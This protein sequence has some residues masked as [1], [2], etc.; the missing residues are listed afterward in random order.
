M[1]S[2]DPK[3]LRQLAEA[4]TGQS[5]FDRAASLF[6]TSL[7]QKQEEPMMSVGAPASFDRTPIQEEQP[8]LEPPKVKTKAAPGKKEVE[9]EDKLLAEARAYDPK[10][11]KEEPSFLDRL[12]DAGLK[13]IEGMGDARL[14][15]SDLGAYRPTQLSQLSIPRVD[16]TMEGMRRQVLSNIVSRGR[17]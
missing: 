8:V 13:F 11:Q 15:Q 12:G 16:D 1:M 2:L 17:R 9:P 14:G 10:K 7:P 6:D 5:D 4:K 3:K